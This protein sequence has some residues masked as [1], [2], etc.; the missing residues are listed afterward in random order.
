VSFAAGYFNVI[1]GVAGVGKQVPTGLNAM[2]D[3]LE[4]PLLPVEVQSL[5]YIGLFDLRQNFRQ[6]ESLS[7]R[8]GNAGF[9]W[10]GRCPG[11]MK[12][13]FF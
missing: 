3:E 11:S 10:R 12:S 2:R 1:H 7:L 6:C 5:V 13:A 9:S 8:V 4:F